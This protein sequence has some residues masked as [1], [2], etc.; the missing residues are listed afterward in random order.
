MKSTELLI[1]DSMHDAAV[2]RQQDLAATR[3]RR[4]LLV[5]WSSTIRIQVLSSCCVLLCVLLLLG[6]G[7]AGL[8]MP[9]IITTVSANSHLYLALAPPCLAFVSTLCAVT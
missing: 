6:R 3:W 8:V 4:K 1:Q 9:Y 7:I 5:S 2:V